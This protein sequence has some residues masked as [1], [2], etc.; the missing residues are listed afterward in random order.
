[1]AVWTLS[2]HIHSLPDQMADGGCLICRPVIN[3]YRR[4]LSASAVLSDTSPPWWYLSPVFGVN[5]D[6][7]VKKNQTI[8]Q[9][10]T[11]EAVFCFWCVTVTFPVLKNAW[12]DSES[13]VHNVSFDCVWAC[14]VL[15]AC[16]P[17]VFWLCVSLVCFD[18]VWAWCVLTVCE[19]VVFWLCVSLLCFD[20]VWA[21]CVLTVCEPGVFWLCVSLVCFVCVWAWCVLTVCEPGVFWLCG[22]LL[23]FYSMW[24][25][26]VFCVL[27]VWACCVLTACEPSVFW[28]RLVFLSQAKN[29][30]QAEIDA[31]AELVD[32]LRFNVMF[33]QVS[34]CLYCCRHA[35][36]LFKGEFWCGL[37]CQNCECLSTNKDNVDGKKM[38]QF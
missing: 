22:S 14:C 12:Q 15:T 5:L 29:I 25:R 32:F 7:L 8:F 13:I 34:D 6:N 1:M 23:C 33:A 9:P 19:P 24:A 38:S 16:E 36:L 3:K 28:L 2:E 20:C 11:A 26:C 18:C 21:C 17:V 4:D 30:V 27:T 37:A 31:A 10:G 35:A